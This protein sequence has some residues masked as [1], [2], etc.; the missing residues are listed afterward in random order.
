MTGDRALLPLRR[1]SVELARHEGLRRMPGEKSQAMMRALIAAWKRRAAG[2]TVAVACS[3]LVLGACDPLRNASVEELLKRAEVHRAAGELNATVIELKNALQKDSQN[4]T[5]RLMLGQAFIDLGD[6][7]SAEIELQRAAQFGAPPVQAALL[8]GE[9]KLQQSRFD[10]VLRDHADDEA[11]PAD[12]RAAILTLRGRAHAGLGQRLFAEEAFKAALAL[13]GKSVDSLVGL[14]RL[15]PST[16]A[17]AR[18]YAARAAAIAPDDVKVL[19]LRA[20][21]A[22]AAKELDAAE[23]FY[24]QILLHRKDDLAALHAQLGIARTHIAG[25]KIREA[26]GRL[27]YQLTLAPAEPIAH[28]LRALA[29]YHSKDFET[30]KGHSEVALHIAPTH[31]PSMFVAGAANYELGQYEQ[32]LLLLTGYIAETPNNLEARKLLAATQMKVGQPAKAVRTLQP[33]ADG[34]GSEDAQLLAMLGAALAQTGDMRTAVSYLERAVAKDPGNAGLRAQLGATQVAQ[35]NVAEGIG[36]LEQAVQQDTQGRAD[37]TLIITHLQAK[38]FDKARDAAKR[39]QEKQPRSANGFTLAGLVELNRGDRAAAK[40]AFRK[41]LEVKPDDRNA[42]RQLAAI[43]VTENAFDEGRKYLQNILSRHPGDVEFLIFMSQLETRA[44]R[45]RESLAQLEEALR[46]NPNSKLALVTVARV[47]LLTGEARKASELLQAEMQKS[48]AD[49][50][51]LEILG[52][53]QLA[54]GQPDLAIPTFRMLVQLQRDVPQARQYLADAYE[55][56]GLIDGALAEIEQALWLSNNAPAIQFQYARLQTR[57]GRTD[58]AS[59]MLAELRK[60]HP[61]DAGLLDLEGAIALAARRPRDAVAPY[62]RLFAAYPASVNLMKLARAK[63]ESGLESDAVGDVQTWLQKNP[64]DL[65]AQVM[66]GDLFVSIRQYDKAVPIYLEAI[67]QI[68]NNV[69]VLNNLAWSLTKIGRPGDAVPHAR[70]AAS[71]APDSASVLDTFGVVLTESGQFKEAVDTLRLAA[72]RAPLDPD[73]QFHLAQAMVKD[74]DAAAARDI[75]R[76]ILGGRG[77]IAERAEAELLLKE[78]DG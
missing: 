27:N 24:R 50:G 18:D 11:A 46:T 43:A 53:A 1:V 29:A 70:R 54:L 60:T 37:I 49:A 58:I 47:Y 68:P 71:L 2:L 35:G 76:L 12:V 8:L 26:I 36:A 52:R 32:A 15:S 16:G 62:Q 74:G 40:A 77:Q 28:Y 44:G 5:A 19:A 55:N 30:A 34:R 23:A 69:A 6:T 57:A 13:D 45:P 33:V 31:A 17:M 3:M 42:S 21:M 7:Q 51:M 25:G 22:F 78:I 59:E 9:T 41:A 75:L 72:Q 48:G 56:A 14:A 63:Q 4:A 64:K 67:R 10:Q 66:L 73:I 65:L 20:E 39:L 61:D 38:D